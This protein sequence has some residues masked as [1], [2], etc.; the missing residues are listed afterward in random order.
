MYCFTF[1]WF[2]L[3]SAELGWHQNGWTGVGGV[4][5]HRQSELGSI[6]LNAIGWTGLGTE[7]LDHVLSYRTGISFSALRF[8]RINWD[9]LGCARI[10]RNKLKL[11][12]L[13]R[14]CSISATSHL[15]LTIFITHPVNLKSCIKIY[16]EIIW[17]LW[18]LSWRLCRLNTLPCEAGW[19]CLSILLK[20]QSYFQGLVDLWNI[21]VHRVAVGDFSFFRLHDRNVSQNYFEFATKFFK[22]VPEWLFKNKTSVNWPPELRNTVHWIVCR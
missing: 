18:A 4:R 16:L 15:P 17:L 13:V 19:N 10:F 8:V 5:M 14:D 20:M 7:R 1:D 12:G 2:G 11:V 6:K 3:E 21:H 9:R 22:S